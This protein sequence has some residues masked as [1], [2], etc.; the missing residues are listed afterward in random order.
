MGSQQLSS[1]GLPHRTFSDAQAYWMR[2]RGVMRFSALILEVSAARRCMGVKSP[3]KEGI[4]QSETKKTAAIKMRFIEGFS[5]KSHK[6]GAW[7]YERLPPGVLDELERPIRTFKKGR[8]KYTRIV[9]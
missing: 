7:V 8:R 4:G 5:A 2:G 6:Y 3:A 1:P 9:F